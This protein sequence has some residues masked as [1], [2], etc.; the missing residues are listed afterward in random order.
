MIILNKK[1]KLKELL[2]ALA[3]PLAVGGVSAF[4]TKDA[5][6]GYQNLRQPPLSPPPWLFPV[7]W[8]LLYL[9]MGTASYLVCTSAAS[10]PRR[11]KALTVYAVQLAANFCW[12]VIFFS[13]RLYLAS[14][15]WLLALWTLILIATVMFH[16]IR[17]S[18][19]RLMLPYLAWVTFAGYLNLGVYLLN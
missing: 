10:E 18:A 3:I 1:I 7:V 19:G 12:P 9:A 14:F 5:M 6:S 2:I 11:E 13:M 17:R 15:I 4:I 16:Y 8:T